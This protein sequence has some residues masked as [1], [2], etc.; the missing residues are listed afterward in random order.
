MRF[1]QMR[2]LRVDTVKRKDGPSERKIQYKTLH[3]TLFGSGHG[4][5]LHMPR[6]WVVLTNDHH[7]AK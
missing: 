5:L 7:Q 4:P 2:V 3:T 6:R 1:A